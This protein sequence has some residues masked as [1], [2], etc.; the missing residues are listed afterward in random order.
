MKRGA[1][2]NKSQK[3]LKLFSNEERGVIKIWQIRKLSPHHFLMRKSLAMSTRNETRVI[4][5]AFWA[6][7]LD[8]SNFSGAMTEEG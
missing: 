2:C 7:L 8:L 1:A 5:G 3:P 6:R 4:N